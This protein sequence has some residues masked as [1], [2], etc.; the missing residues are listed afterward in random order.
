MCDCRHPAH[1]HTGGGI[2]HTITITGPATAPAFADQA[3]E[4]HIGRT[5]HHCPCS[6]YTPPA[7]GVQVE[8]TTERKN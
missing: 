5:L 6:R 2:C 4:L 3:P 8:T 1:H 7:T